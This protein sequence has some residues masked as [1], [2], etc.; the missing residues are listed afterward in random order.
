MC[1][2]LERVGTSVKGRD[3]STRH[4]MA[5]FDPDNKNSLLKI[6]KIQNT[7]KDNS[8]LLI[9]FIAFYNIVLVK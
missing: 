3:R 8:L 9:V 2:Q 6:E 4:G 5:I 7:W 1:N